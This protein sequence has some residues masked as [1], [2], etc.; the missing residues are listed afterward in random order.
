MT[1]IAEYATTELDE[2]ETHRI[3]GCDGR[4]HHT[5]GGCVV[6]IAEMP[7][8]D[9]GKVYADLVAVD[10]EAVCIVVYNF[11][12]HTDETQGRFTTPADVRTMA[13]RYRAFADALDASADLLA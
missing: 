3:P 9:Q 5:D 8:G 6:D 2:V 13:A 11:D 10:D 12:L 1:M 4:W 7:L